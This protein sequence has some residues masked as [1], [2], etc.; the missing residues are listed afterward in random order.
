[1]IGLPEAGAEGSEENNGASSRMSAELM[2]EGTSK[3]LAV[4]C[5]RLCSDKA[6]SNGVKSGGKYHKRESEAKMKQRY[7]HFK[8]SSDVSFLAIS[9]KLTGF[10]ASKM[11]RSG[12][13]SMYNIGADPDDAS[14]VCAKL[15]LNNFDHLGLLIPSPT[16]SLDTRAV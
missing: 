12:L 10:P 4:E 6:R 5:A 9:M 14:L 16:T 1:M 8:I 2:A 11:T 3:S 7:Y 15:V 13:Q